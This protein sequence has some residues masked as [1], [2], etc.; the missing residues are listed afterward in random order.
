[1]TNNKTLLP[2]R[3]VFWALVAISLSALAEPPAQNK[4]ID[5]VIAKRGGASVN[6]GLVDAKMYEIPEKDRA[7]FIDS[8]KRIESLLRQL[9]L[10]E[11]LAAEAKQKSLDKTQEYQLRM[12]LASKLILTSMRTQQLLGEAPAVDGKA[13]AK[14]AYLADPSKF[15]L[16][17]SVSLRHI[18][19]KAS[20]GAEDEK[21]KARIEELRSEIVDGRKKFEDLAK[22]YSEDPGTKDKGG[23]IE[24]AEQMSFVEPFKKALDELKSKNQLSPIVKTEYGYHIIQLVDRKPG[25]QL[26]LKEA[27]AQFAPAKEAEARARYRERHI[28]E[29]Q[30]LAIDAVPENVAALRDRYADQKSSPLLEMSKVPDRKTVEEK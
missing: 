25:K 18:L 27:V 9:L 7:G 24:N 19:I 22:I 20:G 23:L 5:D 1:M 6:Y 21:A 28:E 29:L 16:S 13:L 2:L 17:D 8:G 12:D 4:S 14:E 3:G 15:K 26:S 30:S 11:Q 10:V